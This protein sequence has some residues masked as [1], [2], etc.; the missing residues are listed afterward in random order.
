MS[1]TTNTQNPIQLQ[2]ATDGH[3]FKESNFIRYMLFTIILRYAAPGQRVCCFGSG[4]GNLIELL[5]RNKTGVSSFYA[6]DSDTVATETNTAK[7]RHLQWASFATVDLKSGSDD[8][9]VFLNVQADMVISFYAPDVALTKVELL[10][11]IQNCFMCGNSEATYFIRLS[12]STDLISEQDIILYLTTYFN[13]IQRFGTPGTVENFK[14]VMN[15]WQTEMYRGL[16]SY[17]SKEQV[18]AFMAP[19]FPDQCGEILYVLKRK[20]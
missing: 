1:L 8:Y 10:Y 13:I 6:M 14:P 17:Y 19:E 7:W 11:Y 4:G 3:A 9:S 18:S 16:S 5:Y 12:K 2:D 20:V 15:E